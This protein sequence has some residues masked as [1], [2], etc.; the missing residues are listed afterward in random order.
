MIAIGSDHG[1]FDLKEVVTAHLKE[2]GIPYKDFGCYDKKSCDYPVYGK[3]VA[4]AVA[5]GECEKGIVICTNRYLHHGQQGEGGA[6]RPVCGYADG[7]DDTSAQRCE[8]A[9]PG[10]PY[11]GSQSGDQHRGYVFEY[12]VLRGGEALPESR[13]DRT[14]VD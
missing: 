13:F 14:A 6:L 8:C 10:R 9:C 11:R 7:T 3:A 12:G 4:E 2:Q 5:K 1:G